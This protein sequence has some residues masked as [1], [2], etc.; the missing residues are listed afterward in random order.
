[1]DLGQVYVTRWGDAGSRVIM[2]HGS[3]QGSKVGGDGHFARQ[4]RLAG[5]GWQLLVP[6]RPGHGRS[7]APGR[8]D[9]A[10][11]DGIWV[12]GLLEDGAHLVGHSFGGA[13]A[14][15]AAARRPGAVR[16]LTV[17][18]PAMQKL[19]IHSPHVRR[20]VLTMI[21]IN[22]FSLSDASRIR[23]VA[24]LLGIPDEIRGGKD[25][26]ELAAM[27]RSM[28]KLKIPAKADIRRELEMIRDAGIPFMVVSGGWSPAFEATCDAVAALGGGRREVIKS[29]HHFPQSISEEFNDL[30]DAFMRDAEKSHAVSAS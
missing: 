6:D 29:P 8:P 9:D 22:L 19:A 14:L 20:L 24:Q 15:A 28:R 11:A 4:E 21:G 26:A 10:E 2:V 5:Q 23:K 25:P 18:E 27:G 16:S 13:V 30:L 17:I 1:M 12:A 7:P 3:G